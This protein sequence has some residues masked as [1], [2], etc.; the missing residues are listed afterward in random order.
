M[1]HIPYEDFE[2][3]VETLGLIGVET[4]AKLKRRYLQ[5]SKKY[6]PDMPE[7]SS[8][9]FQKI[10][11]SYKIIQTYMDNFRFRFTKEEFEDQHPFSVSSE[12]WLQKKD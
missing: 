4:R 6:H 11:K 10:N 12:F 3:A 7:G 8:E 2:E 1:V 9:K 5:L